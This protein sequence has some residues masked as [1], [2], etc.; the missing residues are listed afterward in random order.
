M[1]FR[2]AGEQEAAAGLEDRLAGRLAAVQVVAEKDRPEPFHRRA[3][4]LQPPLGGLDFAVL[5]FVAVLGPDDLR[6]Q[7][8]Q[9]V[10]SRRDDAR[11]EHGVEV[12]GLAVRPHA[13]GAVSAAELVGGK[14]LGAV[15]G[16]EQPS[17]EPPQKVEAAAAVEVVDDVVEHSVE[18]LG[19]GSVE[20]V[21]YV[22]V[23]GDPLDSEQGAG[24]RLAPTGFEVLLRGQEGRALQKHHGEGGHAEVGHRQARV[25]AGPAVRHG[26]AEFAH[27]PD[28]SREWRHGCCKAQNR[29]L[30][31]SN[32]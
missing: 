23:A 22:V 17:V 27:F 20:H 32:I 25:A 29:V 6:R 24:V 9:E 31:N 5:L 1:R 14:V 11:S 8:Q 16:D 21:A 2:L 4:S 28:I 26:G 30:Y 18:M 7:R 19:R 3:D 15:E 13:R 12:L 10:G